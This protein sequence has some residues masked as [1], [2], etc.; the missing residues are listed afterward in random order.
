MRHSWPLFIIKHTHE[1]VTRTANNRQS[2]TNNKITGQLVSANTPSQI[3]RNQ[4]DAQTHSNF[5]E[6]HPVKRECS[7]DST[8]DEV[9]ARSDNRYKRDVGVDYTTRSRNCFCILM[10]YCCCLRVGVLQTNRGIK[11]NKSTSESGRRRTITAE[12]IQG[13]SS[14]GIC[15]YFT[16]M[17]RKV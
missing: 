10:A 1:T 9:G 4:P 3:Y 15:N 2:T 17:K 11:S 14:Q 7:W 5:S 16:M 13:C 8:P 6:T 12:D